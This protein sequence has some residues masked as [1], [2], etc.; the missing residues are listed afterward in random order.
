M[1]KECP[2]GR[3]GGFLER[4]PLARAPAVGPVPSGARQSNSGPIEPPSWLAPR[5]TYSNTMM[6]P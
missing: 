5:K 4:P 6:V 1:A 2:I 3:A